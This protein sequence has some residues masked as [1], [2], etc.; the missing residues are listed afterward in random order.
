MISEPHRTEYRAHCEAI[1]AVLHE[2]QVPTFPP[3]RRDLSAAYGRGH[4]PSLAG[5]QGEPLGDGSLSAVS[6]TEDYQASRWYYCN[7][8]GEAFLVLPLGLLFPM[9]H[10]SR[11]A[12]G[13]QFALWESKVE[14]T[15][16]EHGWY[17]PAT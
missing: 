17:D 11:H 7:D 5:A 16:M 4:P 12:V 15:L 13:M 6:G 9:L 8:R 1:L 14:A 10:M 3:A 2:A